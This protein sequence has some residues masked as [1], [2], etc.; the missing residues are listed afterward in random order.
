MVR[1]TRPGNAAAPAGSPGRGC[2]EQGLSGPL[3]QLRE[4]SASFHVVDGR[5]TFAALA[6]SGW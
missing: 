5:M 2:G 1:G 6:G 3:R 4:A